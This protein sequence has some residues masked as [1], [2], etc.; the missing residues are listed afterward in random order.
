[1]KMDIE[2]A[3]RHVLTRNTEWAERVG[4]IKVEVHPPYAIDECRRDLE[5]LG[6][7][8]TRHHAYD[9]ALVGVRA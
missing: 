4:C 3:E 9:A 5:G 1:M 2:G 7:A 6:F 8:V